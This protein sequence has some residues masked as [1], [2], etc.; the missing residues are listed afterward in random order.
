LKFTANLSDLEGGLAKSRKLLESWGRDAGRLISA[1]LRLAEGAG[2]LVGG[3][4]G[5]FIGPIAQALQAI[6]LIGSAFAAI[7]TSAAGF[8]DWLKSALADMK[9]IG[10]EAEALGLT[11]E[12]LSSLLAAAGPNAE[13]MGEGLAHL[14]RHLGEL[15]VGNTQAR[16]LFR[17]IGLD[18]DTL[19][20]LAGD[21][22]LGAVMDAFQQMPNAMQRNAAALQ[23]FGRGVTEIVPLLSQGSKG[24]EEFRK[25]AEKLGLAFSAADLAA[26]ASAAKAL[27]AIEQNFAGI[28]RQLAIGL[29]PLIKTIAE[30]MESWVVSSGG[31]KEAIRNAFAT[32]APY[33]A[34]FLDALESLVVESGKLVANLQFMKGLLTLPVSGI[35]LTQQ[36]GAG[37]PA[38]SL[39][40]KFL[41]SMSA[42]LNAKPGAQAGPGGPQTNVEGLAQ[43]LQFVQS[44]QMQGLNLFEAYDTKVQLLKEAFDANKGK[45][46]DL[47]EEIKKLNEELQKGIANKGWEVFDKT[48]TPLEKF[49]SAMAEMNQLAQQGLKPDIL[50]RGRANLFEQLRQGLPSTQVQAPS[51]MEAGSAQAASAIAGVQTGRDRMFNVQEQVKQVLDQAL[52]FQKQTE[53]HTAEIAKALAA[54][55]MLKQGGLGP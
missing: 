7:P 49:K 24:L 17:N 21:K 50:A 37:G 11:T 5:G 8:T 16:N 44:V 3:A 22:A 15:Q 36:A 14:S 46:L 12:T 20:T 18:P 42:L 13:K 33:V 2:G 23:L 32:T 26:I 48:R 41:A 25:R 1:P 30:A 53:E 38:Q 6:P 43:A 45:A 19:A 35:P 28:Q 10:R 55:P 29:A 34:T 9:A 31:A 54:V 47:A 40:Q 27:K 39:G 52:E 51:L 4:A